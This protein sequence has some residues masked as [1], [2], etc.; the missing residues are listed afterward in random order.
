[1]ATLTA[2]VD[3]WL[4]NEVRDFWKA[5]G[6]GPS[7]GFRHIV[8]EWWTLQN[9]PA[10]EFRDGVSGRRAGLRNGPDVW[11]VVLTARDYG[12]DLDALA[13]HFGGL[14]PKADLGQALEYAERFPGAVERRI[15]ENL[16]IERMLNTG[17]RR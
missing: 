6:E 2:R 17:N 16:R 11:E 3:D 12:G 14:L 13:E 5:H 4:D 1:M 10:L 15:E 7:S 8:E 9:L